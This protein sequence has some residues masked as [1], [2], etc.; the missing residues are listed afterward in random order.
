MS[1]WDKKKAALMASAAAVAILD[2]LVPDDDPVG[3][4]LG[5]GWGDALQLTNWR[6]VPFGG[7]PGFDGLAEIEGH[8][9]KVI[10]GDLGGRN[11]LALSGRVHLNEHPYDPAIPQMVRLQTEMLIK[12]GV[13]TLIVTCAAGSLDSERLPARHI[14]VT[15]GFVTEFA[16]PMPL[17]A[18]EFC[19]PEDMLDK[20]LIRRAAYDGGS[21]RDDGKSRIR[22]GGH[23]MVRGPFFEG[24]KYDKP[25]LARTG[26]LT[27]GMSTLPEACIAAIYGVRVLA[28]AYVSNNEVEE[29]S[30][31]ENLRR[32][33]EDQEFLASFLEKQV[34]DLPTC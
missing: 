22:H 29:H 2:R 11:V 31:E 10:C 27:V 32:A 20:K 12:A 16:P 3:L 13:G 26:A 6:S 18:G 5:T 1:D 14:C 17:F 23:V 28:L 8:E 21:V 4:V 15:D 33:R 25:L 7:V 19:N 34:R 30:H 24:R 9:R